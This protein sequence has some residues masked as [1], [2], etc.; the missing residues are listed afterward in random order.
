MSRHCVWA[1]NVNY[2]KFVADKQTL[3]ITVGASKVFSTEI[4][5]NTMIIINE[6]RFAL[7][8]D[9]QNFP[10]LK[11]IGNNNSKFYE[12][13]EERCKNQKISVNGQLW[14]FSGKCA[15]IL[16]LPPRFF[17]NNHWIHLITAGLYLTRILGKKF[18]IF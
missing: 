15:G 6:Q 18:V 8:V 7:K 17:Y 16:Y 4:D 1:N 3:Y 13:G 14:T 9:G 2:F 5:S 10:K 12:R 11:A